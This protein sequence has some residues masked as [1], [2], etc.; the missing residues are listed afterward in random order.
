MQWTVSIE[1]SLRI[2]PIAETLDLYEW[3]DTQI[4]VHYIQ[5]LYYILCGEELKLKESQ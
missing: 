4:P 1:N 2:L 3:A 5:N